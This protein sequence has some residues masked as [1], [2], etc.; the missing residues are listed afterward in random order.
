MKHIRQIDGLRFVA[1]FLVLIAHLASFIGNHFAAGYYGV[2]L[3]FVISGFLITNI[4]VASRGSFGHS[5]KRFI[6]RR[7]L[8]IFPIYY[9]T[10]FILYLARDHYTRTYIFNCLTYTYNY[11]WVYYHI[12]NNAITHFWSLCVEEQFYLFWPL[13]VLVLRHKMQLLKLIML[14]I[15]L[16]CAAQISFN[17]FPAVSP[18]N[19]IGL[20]PRAYPLVLGGM[21]ALLFREGK[22]PLRILED[23]RLEYLSLVLLIFFMAEDFGLRN[24]LCPIISLYFIYKTAHQGFRIKAVNRFL[25]NKWVV[26]VGTISYGIYV[27]HLPM[28]YYFTKY[29]FDPYFW[30]KIPFNSHPWL[31]KLRWHSWIIKFPL[32]TFMTIGI[33]GLSFK[34]IE[35]PILKFKDRFFA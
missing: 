35:Q 13:L 1:L 29:V 34:Y 10:V 2:D 8:R 23:I 20:F 28:E 22:V 11:A 30:F 3:F 14:L 16:L 26:Y 12:P 31:A 25:G 9:L 15:L 18:Y 19:Y 27:Y 7:T 5:Y 24:I 21:G 4:L 32:Y 33:A 17:I 6:G